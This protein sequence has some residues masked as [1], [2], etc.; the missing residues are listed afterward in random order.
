MRGNRLPASLRLAR[1]LR[2]NLNCRCLPQE[3]RAAMPLQG[4]T[5]A[6]VSPSPWKTSAD[7][8]RS[9]DPND[10][11]LLVKAGVKIKDQAAI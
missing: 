7:T 8:P 4:R 6:A 9:A 10:K 3:R 5:G 2:P 11:F 1:I